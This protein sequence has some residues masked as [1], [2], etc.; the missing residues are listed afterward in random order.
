MRKTSPLQPSTS[1]L[2]YRPDIDGLRAIAVIFVL[3]FHAF[4]EF[5]PG[6]FIGVDVFFVI[7]GFLISEIIFRNLESG[8]FSFFEFYSKRIR[9]IFPAL[10][11]VLLSCYAF[12]WFALFASEYKLLGKHIAGGATFISNYLY[13]NEAGYF[14]IAAE[15]KPLL[16]L[17]SLGVEEQFYIFWPLFMYLAWKRK[18]NL[19]AILFIVGTSFY[20][21]IRGMAV[22]PDATFYSSKVRFWE[23]CSGSVLAYFSVFKIPE[24]SDYQMD[25]RFSRSHP[26]KNKYFQCVLKS[27]PIY[28]PYLGVALIFTGAITFSKNLAYPGYW[29]LIP[30]AGTILLLLG[31]NDSFINRSLLSKK[32]LVWIGLISY[33][34]YLWH[35]PILS[36]ARIVK[37]QSL[38]IP[39]RVFALILSI[40]L[41]WLT[42]QFVEKFFRANKNLNKKV[43][44]LSSLMVLVGVTGFYTFKKNGL[45]FRIQGDQFHEQ[46]M[47]QFEWG[48]ISQTSCVAKYSI[49]SEFDYC[50]LTNP[51][52]DPTAALIGDSH[53]NHFFPGLSKHFEAQGGNLLNTGRGGCAPFFFN[54]RDS[55]PEIWQLDSASTSQDAECMLA[56][57]RM[58]SYVL[59]N[60]HIK[61]VFMAFGYGVLNKP[62][63]IRTVQALNNKSKKVILISDLPT[64]SR[65]ISSCYPRPLHQHINNPCDPSEMY[66][67]SDLDQYKKL[68]AEA[69]KQATFE[70]FDTTPFLIGNFPINQNGLPMYRD[71]SHLSKLG[72]LFFADKYPTY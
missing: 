36:F 25:C 60:P 64:L 45:D 47:N 31:G 49:T 10:I 65:D 30:V 46:V 12:G 16:H 41:A 19:I 21:N 20:L 28:G 27:I 43:L 22:N 69:R 39:E 58:Y 61:T 44:F 50:N 23:L 51:N 56:T 38:S 7:S 26:I 68:I 6:G 57:Q 40:I 4:P 11:L 63:L 35:W 24:L 33:P 52:A 67:L 62:A 17:W 72:S 42:Y 14:D 13:L 18:L 29:A 15:K 37:N 48:P 59:N 9:R 66:R 2:K 70:I 32:W 71:I 54:G 53:A 3:L 8:H 5:L 34:L 55:K 1:H